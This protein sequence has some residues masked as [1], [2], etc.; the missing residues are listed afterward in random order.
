MGREESAASG[1]GVDTS[2]R[3]TRFVLLKTGEVGDDEGAGEDEISPISTFTSVST[4]NRDL[5]GRV[6]LCFFSGGWGSNLGSVSI[7]GNW[8]GSSVS[9][10]DARRRYG[11]SAESD[12]SM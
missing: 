2:G 3:S 10:E 5:G 6:V 8:K 12:T 7:E 4:L 9:G 1:S 11:R